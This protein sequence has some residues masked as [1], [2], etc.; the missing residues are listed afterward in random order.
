MQ[1]DARSPSCCVVAEMRRIALLLLQAPELEAGL[2]TDEGLPRQRRY[3]LLVGQ[4]TRPLH[5]SRR[6]VVRRLL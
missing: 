6:F 1:K 5:P 4:L 2:T 3:L